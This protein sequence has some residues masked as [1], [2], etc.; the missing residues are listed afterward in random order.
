MALSI[1]CPKCKRKIRKVTA[2]QITHIRQDVHLE[3][4]EEEFGDDYE[5]IRE[6]DIQFYC[7]YCGTEIADNEKELN[8]LIKR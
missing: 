3:N 2:D 1:R 6:D 7:P 4:W 8:K 5:E